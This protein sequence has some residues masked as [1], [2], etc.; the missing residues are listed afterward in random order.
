MLLR[1]FVIDI[2]FDCICDCI[3]KY[4]V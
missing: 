4:T 1:Y 2:C 3:I